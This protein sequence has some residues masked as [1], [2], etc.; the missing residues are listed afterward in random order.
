MGWGDKQRTV[1][2]QVFKKRVDLS[3]AGENDEII[4][5]AE[6]HG[7][8]AVALLGSERPPPSAAP[9]AP[10]GAPGGSGRLG[11]PRAEVRPLGAPRPPRGLKRAASK[12]AVFTACDLV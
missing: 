12:V 7:P 1:S 2:P 6:Q 5:Q 4:P 10:Y 11:T 8:R 9:A 3:M